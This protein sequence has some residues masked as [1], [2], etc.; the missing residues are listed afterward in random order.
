[1]SSISEFLESRIK[2][3]KKNVERHNQ[4][5][6]LIKRLPDTDPTAHEQEVKEY[7]RRRDLD[8]NLLDQRL[9]ELA[10]IQLSE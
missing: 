8:Q 9:Q 10:L 7:E 2:A 4:H 5:L 6:K 1:M 3:L